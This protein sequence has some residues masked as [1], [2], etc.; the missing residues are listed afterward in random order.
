MNDETLPLNDASPE[1]R[2][3]GFERGLSKPELDAI[4]KKLF[5]LEFEKI[6][7]GHL[8]TSVDLFLEEQLP[9]AIQLIPQGDPK[10]PD[11]LF[12]IGYDITGRS[13]NYVAKEETSLRLKLANARVGIERVFGRMLR[14]DEFEEPALPRPPAPPPAPE[15]HHRSSRPHNGHHNGH[16]NGGRHHHGGQE[17]NNR[18][19]SARP[20]PRPQG[21]TP[22]GHADPARPQSSP[23]AQGQNERPDSRERKAKQFS[24]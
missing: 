18:Q 1:P 11:T 7:K 19:A 8:R 2:Y 24:R 20:N 9:N 12:A 23:R 4:C 10:A 6:Q 13:E 17:R 22:S 15:T 3:I 21:A 14:I 16:H 5:P